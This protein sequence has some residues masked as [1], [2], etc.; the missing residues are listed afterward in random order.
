MPYQ[1]TPNPTAPARVSANFPL[2]AAS[3][4]ADSFPTADLPLPGGL[5]RRFFG[6]SEALSPESPPPESAKGEVNNS[7]LPS[8]ALVSR[9][10]NALPN[11]TGPRS[12][13]PPSGTVPADCPSMSALFTLIFC[14]LFRY[15][16]T[17]GSGGPPIL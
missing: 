11:A 17:S 13:D 3:L 16:P 4:S 5:P 15:H 12:S 2:A 10:P 7:L 9:A 6:A 1:E 8:P 14:H